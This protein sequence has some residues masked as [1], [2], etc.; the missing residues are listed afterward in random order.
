MHQLIILLTAVL[1]NEGRLY[2][3]EEPE[4]HLHSHLQRAFIDFLVNE[5][6]NSYV[7]TTHSPSIINMPFTGSTSLKDAISVIALTNDGTGSTGGPITESQAMLDAIHDIGI[8][9][10]D[11]LQATGIIWVEGPSDRIYLNRWIALR[12]PDLTE[13]LHYHFLYYGGRLLSHYEVKA[14][15]DEAEGLIN[16]LRINRNSIVIID[17]DRRAAGDAISEFKSR[18]EVE[19]AAAGITCWITAGREIE[20]YVH[21]DAVNRTFSDQNQLG[22][23]LGQF[24]KIDEELSSATK[25]AGVRER[26]YENGKVRYSKRIAEHIERNHT[27]YDLEARMSMLISLIRRWN[28]LPVANAQLALP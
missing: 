25:A 3:I 23:T 7:I 19:A 13:G 18:V 6:S 21:D 4:I 17:S 9:A 28:S 1:S 5:T 8:N 26:K 16:L 10:S 12:A 15:E 22:Y 24:G 11:L 27:P 20:N 2:G 14:D